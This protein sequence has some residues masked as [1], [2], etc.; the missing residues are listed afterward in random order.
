MKNT[1]NSIW[2]E[3]Q[4]YRLG[5]HS[6][7]QVDWSSFKC[8]GYR[9]STADARVFTCPDVLPNKTHEFIF[10]IKIPGGASG[11]R[12]LAVQ[13]V[14]DGLEWFGG[15]SDWNIIIGDGDCRCDHGWDYWGN[16][17]PVNITKCGY[18]VCGRDNQ[19]YECGHSGWFVRSSSSCSGSSS[20]LNTKFGVNST[21]PHTDDCSLKQKTS[22]LGMGYYLEIANSYEDRDMVV[23]GL[24]C[25]I[26]NGVIPILRICTSI[27]CGFGNV[28]TY[29]NF[30]KYIDD[31]VNGFFYAI[32]GPNEPLTETWIEGQNCKDIVGD[33]AAKC[34]ALYMNAVIDGLSYRRFKDHGGQ[35]GLLSPAF[36]CTNPGMPGF[37]KKMAKHGA[38]FAAL[39]GIAGNSYNI[40]TAKGLT[41]SHY[42]EVCQDA[43]RN[44]GINA[45]YDCIYI[46][47]MGAYESERNPLDGNIPHIPHDKALENLHSQVKKLRENRDV[48]AALFFNAFN[49]SSDPN[50]KYGII[51]DSEWPY[52]LGTG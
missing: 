24:K 5:T 22:S 47:E 26:N 51:D 48:R 6:S 10:N 46:T 20:P 8:G 15:I 44:N 32:A 34:N 3:A 4:M 52:I 13:M 50:Y 23:E 25:A 14:R 21:I 40:N 12:K 45:P 37:V 7:N 27:G 42:I 2:G 38:N 1:G 19:K 35:I 11:S 36:N 39:D 29:I 17:I 16:P 28:Q 18:Q 30:L 49:T 31:H 9:K 41:I 33:G 43:F